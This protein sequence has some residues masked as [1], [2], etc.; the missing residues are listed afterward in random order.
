MVWG[1]LQVL[2][3][4][5][6]YRFSAPDAQFKALIT[7]HYLSRTKL[8]TVKTSTI[9][10]RNFLPISNCWGKK[11]TYFPLICNRGWVKKKFTNVLL[12]TAKLIYPRVKSQARGQNNG[13]R[14]LKWDIVYLCSS[15]TFRDTTSFTEIWV[16]QI[17]RFCKKMWKL[18]C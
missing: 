4:I 14:A 13:S 9:L 16:F 8:Q 17:L 10:D 3:Q 12:H 11:W 1:C 2:G 5:G 18:L 15:I 6:N 7:I